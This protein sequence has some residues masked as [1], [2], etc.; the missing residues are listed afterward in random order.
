MTAPPFL[1]DDQIDQLDALL[2][3]RA[4]PFKGLSL[5][6]LDGFVSAL[7]VGPETVPP[8][9]WQ[10]VV[11]GPTP[12]RWQ[13][14]DEIAEVQT[15]LM[16]LWNG[17]TRRV[18]QGEDLPDALQPLIGLPEDPLAEHPDTL[19]IGRDWAIGFFTG[20][21]LRDQAWDRWLNGEEWIDEIAGLFEQLASG[22][23]PA[24]EH[25]EAAA[26]LS[27]RERLEIIAGIP[28]M[29]ADLHHY[30]IEQLTPREPVRRVETPG[31]NDPCPCGS[32]KKYKACCGSN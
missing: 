26:P 5:E 17:I 14:D 7:V 29:L 16:G 30:R 6:A 2:E 15:L 9:E 3:Q 11:W 22:D 24:L 19:D 23:V 27:Y 20:M 21:E 10:S 12:P 32:G 18:R 8:E 25:G 1:S 4:V 13:T 28:G 31:R